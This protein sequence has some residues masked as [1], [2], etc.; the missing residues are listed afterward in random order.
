MARLCYVC[1]TTEESSR[2]YLSLV[3]KVFQKTA[4]EDTEVV[5]KAVNPGVDRIFPM[6]SLY[7]DYLN[8]R[9]I[10]ERVLEAEKDGFDAAIVGC[11]FD[12]GVQEAREIVNIPVIGMGESSLHFACL[13]GYKIAVV[14]VN[15][16]KATQEIEMNITLQGLKDRLITNG[17]RRISTS[18]MDVFTKGMQEPQLVASDILER[19]RECVR[20]G[21]E[22]V[23]VGCNG[24]GPLCTVSGVSEVEEVH[25][26]ILD[27]VAVSIKVAEALV[28]L[29]R[30]LS[31]PPVSRAR[32]YAMPREKDM[33]RVRETFG[34]KPI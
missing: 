15:D 10:I 21:A 20:D 24:L 3:E 26:P 8:K 7:F 14:T 28:D 11:F 32:L 1:I 13:L 4:R 2:P 6:A 25:A 16:V 9:E 29:Q 34:L 19:S 12:P 22:V 17:V 18:T 27:C 23:L 30:R 33:L 31:L 5:V